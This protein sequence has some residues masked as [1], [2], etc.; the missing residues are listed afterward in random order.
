MYLYEVEYTQAFAFLVVKFCTLGPG[1]PTP[2]G[3]CSPG[4]P[5][6]PGNPWICLHRQNINLI[7]SYIDYVHLI[8]FIW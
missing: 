7:Y 6:R 3:P 8:I 2:S 5:G 1:S 4:I